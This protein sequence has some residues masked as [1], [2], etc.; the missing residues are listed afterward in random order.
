M[1]LLRCDLPPK[2]V[3]LSGQLFGFFQSLRSK[4]FTV[5]QELVFRHAAQVSLLGKKQKRELDLPSNSFG[6]YQHGFQK[7]LDP[8]VY[9]SG[10]L[11]GLNNDSQSLDPV[12]PPDPAKNDVA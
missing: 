7:F 6:T 10:V 3:G 9:K 2:Y 11:V 12:R 8:V 4:S 5:S 1:V